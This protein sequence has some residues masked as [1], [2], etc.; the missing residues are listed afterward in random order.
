MKKLIMIIGSVLLALCIVL[1]VA[2]YVITGPSYVPGQMRH[3]ESLRDPLQ[4]V[5]G[6]LLQERGVWRVAKDIELPYFIEGQGKPVLIVHGGPG[7]PYARPWAGLSSLTDKYRFIYY[8]Q[9]GAGDATRPIERLPGDSFYDDMQTLVTTLGLAPQIAD[10][11]RIRRILGEDKLTIIGHSFGGFMAALYAA[12]FPEHVR[13][14]ILIAPAPMV[15]FPPSDEVNLLELVANGLPAEKRASYEQL[16]ADYLDFRSNLT[17]SERE[18]VELSTRFGLAFK[19]ASESALGERVPA[20]DFADTFAPIG[21]FVQQAIFLSMGM[22]HDYRDALAPVEAPV[23]ILHGE[24]DLQPEAAS[25]LYTNYFSN[26]RLERIANAGH[27]VFAES[28]AAFGKAVSG[29]LSG[30]AD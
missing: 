18:L 12:E 21:G 13:A 8:H 9:R 19:E 3:E 4:P 27:F 7:A 24:N 25:A 15:E 16:I 28:P 22:R 29:F 23:L 1:L 6:N 26:V 11:E 17:K 5:A 14:L 10:I 2:F 20:V 30:L